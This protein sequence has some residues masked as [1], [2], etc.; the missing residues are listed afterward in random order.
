MKK[1]EPKIVVWS[2]SAFQEQWKLTENCLNYEPQQ[3]QEQI[4]DKMKAKTE[5]VHP[6]LPV[7]P[8]F[9]VAA[10]VL[11]FVGYS[12]EIAELLNLLNVNA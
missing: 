7:L 6:P 9:I 5:R 2:D 8:N 3:M 1:E 12:D 11:S 10:V 4:L